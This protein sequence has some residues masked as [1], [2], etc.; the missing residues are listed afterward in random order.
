VQI[1]VAPIGAMNSGVGSLRP[2]SSMDKSR[3]VQSTIMRGTMPQWL[4]ASALRSCVVSSP[5]PPY[6]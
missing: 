6:T 3:L 2:N 4:N 5:Y 1:P